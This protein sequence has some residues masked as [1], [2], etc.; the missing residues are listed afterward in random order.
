MPR[1]PSESHSGKKRC[2]ICEGNFRPQNFGPHFRK[3]E[4]DKRIAEEARERKRELFRIFQANR[5]RA[6]YTMTLP[7]M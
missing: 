3:C 6:S 1:V 5:A 4:R 2:P 7:D